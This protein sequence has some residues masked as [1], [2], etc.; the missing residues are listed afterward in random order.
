MQYIPKLSAKE[1]EENH[2]CFN[3]RLSLYRK[4][5]LDFVENRKFILKKAGPLQGR[6][7]EIGAGTG[8]I[9]LALAK[10]GYKFISIDKDK[11]ALKTA[12]LNLAYEKVLSNVEF[13][14]MDGK[15]MDFGNESFENIV[16]V[17][18]FHHINKINKMLSEIDRVLCANG[19]VVLA[20][21]NKKGMEIVNAVHK[22][23]GRVHE[24]SNVTKDSIYS[25]FRGLGYELKNC[26]DEC[27]WVLIGKKSIK[28]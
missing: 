1:I 17:N 20:D 10:A 19:K 27:H 13:H 4:K 22:Q 3:E 12:A 16:C 6:I 28:K 11:E 8:Y 21:F 14:I 9:T 5:E 23:E 7:L 25:Y 18:L 24:N 15:S 26:G 2:K